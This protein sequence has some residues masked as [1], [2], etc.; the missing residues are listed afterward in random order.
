MSWATGVALLYTAIIVG[1]FLF[2][3]P[4]LMYSVHYWIH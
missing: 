2:W 4:L 1:T 3:W